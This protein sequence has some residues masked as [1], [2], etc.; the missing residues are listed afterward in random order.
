MQTKKT[1]AVL[2]AVLAGLLAVLLG[3]RPIYYLYREVSFSW[4]ERSGQAWEVKHY[5]ESRGMSIGQ[6]PWEIIELY[7]RN[8]E[9]RDFVLNYPEREKVEVDITT[10]SRET[11]PLFLQWDPMWGYADYGS[12]C[13]AV[14]GCGP[15][16]LAMVGYYLTG[17]ESM[18]PEKVAEFARRNGYY[19]KGYG[20]SWTLI[21]QG[22]QKL[23]L[24]ARELPLVKKKITDALEGGNPVIL[25][26]GAGDFTSSGHYIVVRDYQDG[27]FYVNDPNSRLRSE[28][29]W[30]YE[31]L[32]GQIRNIWAIGTKE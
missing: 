20:S 23:G 4:E 29:T 16:C 15:T 6:W 17:D 32:E 18:N 9:T 2:L 19:E 31:E 27:E 1:A 21:S 24:T 10:Y 8:P 5:A 26:L 28:R 3:A 11:V 25:A 7:E 13:I 14:T 30:T 12:S 22:A